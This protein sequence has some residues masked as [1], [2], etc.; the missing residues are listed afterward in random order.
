MVDLLVF[1]LSASKD[2]VTILPLIVKNKPQN[3]KIGLIQA[4]RLI[5][6]LSYCAMLYEI[7]LIML[8]NTKEI[9]SIT[10]ENKV[11][12]GTRHHPQIPTG[13]VL[14]CLHVGLVK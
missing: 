5:Y 13:L 6:P 8:P 12:T 3:V 2:Q 9:L 14:T 1:F 4:C 10:K 11:L 7:A